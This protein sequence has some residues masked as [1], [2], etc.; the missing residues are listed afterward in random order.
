[1]VCNAVE[2]EQKLG[3]VLCDKTVF[4]ETNTKITA[5]IVDIKDTTANV[6]S[7]STCTRAKTRQNNPFTDCTADL[8]NRSFY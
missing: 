5:A 6:K 4:H 1:V 3:P 8:I 7:S 2:R